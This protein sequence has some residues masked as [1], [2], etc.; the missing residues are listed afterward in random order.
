MYVAFAAW[1]QVEAAAHA[2]SE[3]AV[4][5]GLDLYNS[6]I[7]CDGI[8]IAVAMLFVLFCFVFFFV[9][10]WRVTFHVNCVLH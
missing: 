8:F 3:L 7:Y 10:F 5:I 4:N 6:V 1:L 9:V 2:S